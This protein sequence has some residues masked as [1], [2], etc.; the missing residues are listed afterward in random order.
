MQ[1]EE[2]NALKASDEGR[3]KV[4][5]PDSENQG[6]IKSTEA[7]E[8]TAG[9]NE[10]KKEEKK[11]P[12]ENVLLGNF[13]EYNNYAIPEMVATELINIEKIVTSKENN[14]YKAYAL[15][16]K[17]KFEFYVSVEDVVVPDSMPQKRAVLKL[18]ETYK[19]AKEQTQKDTIITTIAQ[20]Q[21]IFTNDFLFKV[22]KEFHLHSK[23]EDPGRIFHNN[24]N[25]APY[26]IGSF[27]NRFSQI[28][29]FSM[30][31]IKLVAEHIKKLLNILRS[32]EKGRIVA[33]KFI[34]K[35]KFD[36]GIDKTYTYKELLKELYSVIDTAVSEKKLDDETIKKV[37]EARKNFAKEV[38]LEN[39]ENKAKSG[40]S[41]K[42]PSPKPS[43][44][45]SKG[46]SGGGGGGKGGGGGGGKGD[47][48]GDSEKK[49]DKSLFDIMDLLL[50][51][52]KT[53][54]TLPPRPI[55]HQA[56]PVPTPQPQPKP[57]QPSQPKPAQPSQPP[58]SQNKEPL[59]DLL[60]DYETGDMYGAALLKS[61]LVLSENAIKKDVKLTKS[62]PERSL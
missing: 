47:S 39:I 13:D 45:G 30:D 22:K 23:D 32:S 21:D 57:T 38:K 55:F 5:R 48:G 28:E 25:L 1:K 24:E 50:E 3:E 51:N 42:K 52:L 33:N 43:S 8:N 14:E 49:K 12:Y 7:A 36:K 35:T 58:Q 46:K 17:I 15:C 53:E 27:K 62:E 31:K 4:K 37:T 29:I 2:N 10:P 61:K 20:F 19:T 54:K 56:K 44:S 18:I 9:N 40:S 60:N 16:G 26:T 59:G 6:P 34:K 11:Q 41:S